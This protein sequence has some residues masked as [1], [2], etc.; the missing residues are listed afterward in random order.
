M[1]RMPKHLRRLSRSRIGGVFSIKYSGKEE[2]HVIVSFS[3]VRGKSSKLYHCMIEL[4]V[5]QCRSC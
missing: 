5:F 1:M 2:M 4:E 3:Y